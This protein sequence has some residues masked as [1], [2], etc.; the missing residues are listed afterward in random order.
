MIARA[1]GRALVIASACVL[2]WAVDAPAQDERGV[3][4]TRA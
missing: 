2:A 3:D 4:R 1:V